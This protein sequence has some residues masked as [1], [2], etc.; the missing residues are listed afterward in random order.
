MMYHNVT[1][2]SMMWHSPIYSLTDQRGAHRSSGMLH[3][4][5][6]DGPTTLWLLNFHAIFCQCTESA[7]GLQTSCFCRLIWRQ[8]FI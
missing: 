8:S 5:V 1:A 3:H 7:F 6:G 4:A 2:G